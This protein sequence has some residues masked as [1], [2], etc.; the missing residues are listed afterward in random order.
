MLSLFSTKNQLIQRHNGHA[1][2]LMSG[3]SNA[4]ISTIG[5]WHSIESKYKEKQ[6]KYFLNKQHPDYLNII[7]I[8]SIQ[9]AQKELQH[10]F[11]LLSIKFIPRMLTLGLFRSIIG[12]F[13][14]YPEGW[15]GSVV[16]SI[17]YRTAPEDIIYQ[18]D[19]VTTVNM[20]H[21]T[22]QWTVNIVFFFKTQFQFKDISRQGS[23][24]LSFREHSKI[25]SRSFC[26]A[27]IVLHMRISS[28]N[29]V[30]VPKTMLWTQ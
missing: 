9:D 8:F 11:S 5:V 20:K 22:M 29:F 28:W 13:Y 4:W 23:V 17:A 6:I 19:P 10:I 30:H 24:L 7:S 16:A 21:T 25:F 1:L 3:R 26:I 18:M 14:P 27:E 2:H 15:Q 12:R